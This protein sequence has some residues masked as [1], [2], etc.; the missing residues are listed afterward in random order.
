MQTIVM[1]RKLENVKAINDEI[2]T[3]TN[4]TDVIEAIFK[5]HI[6]RRVCDSV[7]KLYQQFVRNKTCCTSCIY[8]RLS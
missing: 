5:K 6:H 1:E 3:N 2:N 8:T 4:T 7:L